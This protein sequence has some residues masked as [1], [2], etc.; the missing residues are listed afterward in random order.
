MAGLR[1]QFVAN[2]SRTFD[3]NALPTPLEYLTGRKLLILK[4]RAEWALI[5]C[6]VHKGGEERH[7]SMG[8]SLIDGHFAVTP[9]GPKVAM[10][11]PSIV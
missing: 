8:V 4:S 2:R 7:P 6:P 3:R 1:P 10:C 11:W 5:R 9:A